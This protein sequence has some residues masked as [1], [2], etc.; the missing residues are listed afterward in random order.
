MGGDV[1]HPLQLSLCGLQETPVLLVQVWTHLN[2]INEICDRLQRV[3]D[4]VGNGGCETSGRSKLFRADE[5]FLRPLLGAYVGV[6]TEPANHV[7]GGVPNGFDQGQKR[8]ELTIRSP[9]R[10]RHFKRLPSV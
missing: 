6:R 4:L 1:A 10:K 2:E 3:I 9:Q 7:S 5:S 8:P